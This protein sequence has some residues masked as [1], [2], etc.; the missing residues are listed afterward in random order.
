MIHNLSQLLYINGA[1]RLCDTQKHLNVENIVNYFEIFFTLL[2]NFE[3]SIYFIPFPLLEWSSSL[4]QAV[5]PDGQLFVQYLA[6]YNNINR[7]NSI[8]K[9]QVGSKNSKKTNDILPKQLN[10]FKSGHAGCR[11]I[12]NSNPFGLEFCS[13][14]ILGKTICGINS[15]STLDF[16]SIYYCAITLPI[17]HQELKD[18]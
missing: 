1:Y 5:W 2:S 10:F 15:I 9:S 3:S 7:P 11:T 17:C 8:K 18:V 4:L 13:D 6:I 12:Q 16:Q 14:N